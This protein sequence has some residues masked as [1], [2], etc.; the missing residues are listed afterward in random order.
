M[1]ITY[2]SEALAS[3]RERARGPRD[4]PL[5][6]LAEYKVRCF[7]NQQTWH[8]HLDSSALTE[9]K[10]SPYSA[11]IDTRAALVGPRLA[12][13]QTAIVSDDAGQFKVGPPHLS[14]RHAP[15]PARCRLTATDFATKLLA[16]YWLTGALHSLGLPN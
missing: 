14:P 6:R 16:W 7:V 15:A 9:L 4:R 2:N 8:A 3:M 5:G 13:P 12:L 11:S 1:A 10:A